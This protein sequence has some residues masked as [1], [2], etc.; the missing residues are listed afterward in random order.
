MENNISHHGRVTSHSSFKKKQKTKKQSKMLSLSKTEHSQRN[1][2]IRTQTEVSQNKVFLKITEWLFSHREAITP[3]TVLFFSSKVWMQK[4]TRITLL[5]C[6]K[7]D[8]SIQNSVSSA[9]KK[10]L[11]INN[12]ISQP[13]EVVGAGQSTPTQAWRWVRALEPCKKVDV[14]ASICNPS[15]QWKGRQT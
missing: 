1:P 3:V 10:I 5:L 7:K 13:G 8:L 14:E 6:W 15:T 4:G 12:Y 2:H 11:S 9:G